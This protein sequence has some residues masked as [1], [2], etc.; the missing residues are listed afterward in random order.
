MPDH[1]RSKLAGT[2]IL[3]IAMTAFACG[4][5]VETNRAPEAVGEIT[6]I[7]VVA[8]DSTRIS[9]RQ[10][11]ND[12]DGDE[13]TYS[14]TS[15][16]ASVAAVSMRGSDLTVKGVAPGTATVTVTATDPD[17]LSAEQKANVIVE[18]P[19]QAPRLVTPIP[20]ITV[21]EGESADLD[22]SVNFT[23]PDGDQLSFVADSDDTS[24]ATAT[25]GLLSV[26]VTG[27]SAGT[28]TITVTATDPGGLSVSDDFEVTVEEDS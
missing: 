9:V 19:N 26:T 24:V 16:A 6:D 2:A 14:A 17:S 3:S 28:A 12:P 15:S 22:L 8:G 18:R 10:F 27:V 1:R 23:D 11:F 20:D 21:T 7:K 5:P 25:T 4:D 13:L